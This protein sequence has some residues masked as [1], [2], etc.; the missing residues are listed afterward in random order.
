MR[1]KGEGAGKGEMRE[2]GE[3]K[4]D[5]EKREES[6][7]GRRNTKTCKFSCLETSTIR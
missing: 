6:G 1:G 5:R 4:G 7:G 3:A 2:R